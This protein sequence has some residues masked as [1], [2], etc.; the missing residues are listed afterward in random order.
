MAVDN[1]KES[2]LSFKDKLQNAHKEMEASGIKKFNYN[3]PMLVLLRSLG[4][5]IRPFQYYSFIQ[6]FVITSIWFSTVWGALM[7]FTT[8]GPDNMRVQFA[9]ILSLFAGLL[10]GLIMALYFKSS[11]KSNNL[12]SWEQL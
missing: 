5:N 11:A 2:T 9:L 10:F 6:N 4:L 3:S 1:I 7:W 12:S 8:W